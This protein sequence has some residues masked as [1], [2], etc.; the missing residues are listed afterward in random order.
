MIK[1]N[2]RKLKGALSVSLS[3]A[4][5]TFSGCA[6]SVSE[7]TKFLK[8][9]NYKE[10]ADK[11]QESIDKE[12]NL[13]EAYRGLGLCYWEE[14]DYENASQA[15]GKALE[16]GA[17]ETATI[18]NMLGICALK[19][20]KPE[21][22][23]YYFE[24]GQNFPDAGQELLKEMSFNLIAAYEQVGD[25]QKAKEKLDAYV[26]LYP[27]DERALKEQEFLNT[28]LPGREE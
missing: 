28:Q 21:K 19:M 23:V 24:N 4:M 20:E 27:D 13:G 1:K 7:G 10:A 12:K 25:F 6:S 9:G 8:E 22:A 5:L 2:S 26:E 14:E 11:F 3:I 17:E 16:N 15:F 18:Y